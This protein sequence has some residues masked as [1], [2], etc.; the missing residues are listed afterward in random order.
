M[1]DEREEDALDAEDGI[2]RGAEDHGADVFSGGGLE[3]VRATAGAVADV[4]ADEV[5]DDGGVA[6]IVFGDAGFDFA[7]EVG[8][9][10]S[11]LGVDAAAELGEE[12]D[13]RGAEAE[14]DELVGNAVLRIDRARRRRGRGRRCRG[15]KSA[16]TTRPVTAPP[17]RAICSAPL[18]L[19]RAAEAVRMLARME[20]YMPVKPARPEQMA[21]TRK[22]MTVLTA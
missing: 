9:D 6:G 11:G 18:R 8:A 2:E 19:L 13:E 1:D 10:V 22:L 16:T 21:P 5:G 3:D 20:T 12:G 17:R 14:A 15:A 4:V 7:D